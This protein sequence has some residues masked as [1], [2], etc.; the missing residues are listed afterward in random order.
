MKYLLALAALLSFAPVA[1]AQDASP[2]K[3]RTMV[4]TADGARIGFIDRVNKNTDGTPG[5]VQIIYRGRFVTLPAS[6]LSPVDKGLVTTV[7][8]SDLKNY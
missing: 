3:T 4:K 5:S 2:I 7:T 6:T 1:S 8:A